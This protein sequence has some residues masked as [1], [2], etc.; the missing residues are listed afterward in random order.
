MAESPNLTDSWGIEVIPALSVSLSPEFIE[1]TRGIGQ[2]VSFDF[3]LSAGGQD[4][5]PHG[6]GCCCW[7]QFEFTVE[8]S[9]SVWWIQNM[10]GWW[11]RTFEVWVTS[12]QPAGEIVI[13]GRSLTNMDLYVTATIYVSESP[14]L[15]KIQNIEIADNN[16]MV[17]LSQPAESGAILIVAA[18]DSAGTL[19]DMRMRDITRSGRMTVNDI[20][21]PTA[22]GTRVRAMM[23]DGTGI[24][25]PL[26]EPR[27]TTRTGGAWVLD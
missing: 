12:N 16:V 15:S 4:V 7:T 24:I 17:D 11:N 8:D 21:I 10:S 19:L 20:T 27:T 25:R 14:P 22:E 23:W 5:G 9:E 1:I 18:I 6:I 2:A 26:C 13:T 3:K